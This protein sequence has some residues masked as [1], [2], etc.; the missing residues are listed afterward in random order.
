ML[1][2]VARVSAL[3]YLSSDSEPAFAKNG[4]LSWYQPA[5]AGLTM[6][7]KVILIAISHFHYHVIFTSK[8][9]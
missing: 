8:Y 9:Y 6:Q 2:I 4:V 1:C 7:G 5:G 3:C